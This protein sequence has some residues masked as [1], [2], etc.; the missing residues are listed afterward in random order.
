MIRA[1][2]AEGERK[3]MEV[4]L[5]VAYEGKRP[6]AQGRQALVERRLVGGVIEGPAFWE[7]AVVEWGRTWDW[8]SVERCWLGTDASGVGEEGRGA[9]AGSGASVGRVSL[10]P[11]VAEGA[12][13]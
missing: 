13:T 3:H 8:R 12:W 9:V 11:G 10:A 4:K 7:E 6:T 1:R 5:A 2:D